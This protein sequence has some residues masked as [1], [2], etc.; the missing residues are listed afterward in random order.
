[1]ADDDNRGRDRADQVRELIEQL[2]TRTA[3]LG[4]PGPAGERKASLREAVHRRA[5]VKVVP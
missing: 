3:S 2:K 5:R 4:T 1:M